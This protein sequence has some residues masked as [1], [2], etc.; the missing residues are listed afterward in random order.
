MTTA[1]TT[2]CMREQ[3]DTDSVASLWSGDCHLP[4]EQE[5]GRD[6]SIDMPS[7]NTSGQRHKTSMSCLRTNSLL[8]F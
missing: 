2:R 3:L 1:S 4:I 8:H 5:Y 6:T 7:Y